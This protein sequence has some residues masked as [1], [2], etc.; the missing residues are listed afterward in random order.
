LDS[1]DR[2]FPVGTLLLWK[3]RSPEEEVEF[4]TMRVARE[5]KYEGF[6]VVDGQQRLT[7][8]IQA[9]QEG[10]AP[11]GRKFVYDL[12]QRVFQVLARG[13]AA[14]PEQV[15]AQILVDSAKLMAWMFENASSV[16]DADRSELF[17]LGK[18]VRDYP[19][20]SYV[21]ET[22]DESIVIEIFTRQNT[23]GKR[24]DVTDVFNALRQKGVGQIG[25]TAFGAFPPLNLRELSQQLESE[26]FGTVDES[27]LLRVVQALEG[28]DV[29]AGL[30]GLADTQPPMDASSSLLRAERCIRIAIRFL[31]DDANIPHEMLLPYTL[32]LVTLA[33]FFDAHA[34]PS[35]RTREL[36]ARW[37]WRGAISGSHQGGIVATRAAL[38]SAMQ[39]SEADAV[40]ALLRLVEVDSKSPPLATARFRMS[41]ATSKVIAN[42]MLDQRPCLL[43]G[44]V[45]TEVSA[46]TLFKELTAQGA[47]H[48]QTFLP[49][50][51][52]GR[53][54]SDAKIFSS[55]AN[56]LFHPHVQFWQ[57]R[58]QMLSISP[59]LLWKH[60]L[61]PEIVEMLSADAERA[62]ELRAAL[63][64]EAI[65][66]CV[67]NR[68]AW[69]AADRPAIA[70][71]VIDDEEFK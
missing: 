17:E 10:A 48:Y 39:A 63:I 44:D 34:Y 70:D 18:R 15:P 9:L 55:A 1:I 7:W 50:L 47:Q 60:F 56:Y 21:I 37:I 38:E 3:G 54:A 6:A 20:P 61:T 35:P 40:Q 59:E 49:R 65:Q 23:T 66:R 24:L 16:S 53:S 28:R 2:G 30:K 43:T 45:G 46:A 14:G 19:V 29:G 69:G 27:M 11:S 5:N 58:K 22:T 68:A 67:D 25:P 42:A 36:L 31:R 52:P 64:Q 32:P 41:N 12:Q 4:G 13:E 33:V 62:L 8:L 26:G 57:P 71:L 51:I